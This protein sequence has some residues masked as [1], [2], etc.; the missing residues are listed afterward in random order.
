MLTPVGCTGAHRT[1]STTS[2]ASPTASRL[3]L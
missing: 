1:F 3:N 2:I